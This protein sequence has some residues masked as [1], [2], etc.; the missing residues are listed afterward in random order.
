[1]NRPDPLSEAG[2]PVPGP[3]AKAASTSISMRRVA[4]AV[5]GVLSLLRGNPIALVFAILV[6]L[7][8]SVATVSINA[9]SA[10]RAYVTAE[11]LYSKGQKDALL[12]LQTYLQSRNDDDYQQF[13]ADIVVPLGDHRARLAMQQESPDIDAARQ[14][15]LSAKNHPADVGSMIWLFR[16]GQ[17]IP[18]MAR[19][20]SI[21][22]DA[23]TGI[24]ELGGLV[25]RARTQ[26]IAGRL[27]SPEELAM[28]ARIPTLNQRLTQLESEFSNQLGQAA[29][30]LQ[31]VLIAL[32]GAV[33]LVLITVGGRYMF[34]ATRNQRQNEA[35]IRELVDAVGDAI[36]ACDEAHQV[37]LFNRA[38][39]RMF[40]CDAGQ[41]K[42][43]PIARF[44]RGPL[45]QALVPSVRKHT[46]GGVHRLYAVGFDGARIILEA[47]VSH[48]TTGA[49]VLTI[50]ACRDVTERD[51]AQ[52]RERIKL[53][54]HNLEL[55]RKARTDA[56]TGLPNRAALELSL[57]RSLAPTTASGGLM[58]FAVLF[59]DLDGFKA[60][61][62]SLGHM[63][64]DELLQHVARRLKKAVRAE[65]EVFRVSGDEFVVV[66]QADEGPGVGEVL[67]K[68]ILSAVHEVYQLEDD[69]LARVTVSVGVA[70]FPADG[71]DART[72]LLAADAAMYRAKH[73]G[74][75]SYFVGAGP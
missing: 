28:R 62:D 54:N 50:I 40:G 57:E 68:R 34:R 51:A 32:N 20:I 69:A 14:G 26:I 16:W 73:G 1:M 7:Q 19:A 17:H 4:A 30:T 44:L 42:G 71:L 27:Y 43:Q 24:D 56:L 18:F 15:F 38:A 11:S 47:S 2:S 5:A 64:G 36:L 45:R 41:A 31:A 66:A 52:E 46:A 6:I 39:E 72:L 8:L 33:A 63:A 3:D 23:D 53:S 74:K 35:D 60:V 75:N 37:V 9:L 22:T 10:V 29:R 58:P 59:L 21:W 65:D 61:N 48:I 13:L 70:N 25:T 55:A 49:S 67:A 12:K